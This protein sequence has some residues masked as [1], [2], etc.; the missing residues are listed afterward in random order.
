MTN[1]ILYRL[2]Y[3]ILYAIA[4]IPLDI[5]YIASD[6][7]YLIV[8]HII[9]YRKR[10][11]WENLT[12]AFPGKNEKERK[13]IE[14]N[15]YRHLCDLCI[16]TVKLLCI[17]DK[18]MRKRINIY[19]CETVEELARQKKPIFV[20]LSH[21]GN[22]EWAQEVK[23]RYAQPETTAEIYHRIAN[24]VLDRIMLRIRSRWN[25]ELLPQDE[26]VRRILRFHKT[27]GSF[28]IGF[29]SDQ[30][31][32]HVEDDQWITFLNQPTDMICGAEII[33]RRCGAAFL[34][35][36]IVKSG[37]GHYTMTFIPLTPSHGCKTPYSYTETYMCRLE[38]TIRN[39]PEYWLW[40]HKRW[41]H[42][43]KS[44]NNIGQLSQ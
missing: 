25:G 4:L 23:K 5:L 31:P 29:I 34:Y 35:L 3:C 16:E 7:A 14:R 37:R 41:S 15:F 32:H 8:Y 10:T 2:A 12:K 36:D 11:V 1:N 30:R 9:R 24:P 20:Y 40:S 17:S 18:E 6:I 38:E 33:G 27:G 44:P 42:S 21:Y 43:C 26:A 22:W 19:G 13:V 28:L 39:R